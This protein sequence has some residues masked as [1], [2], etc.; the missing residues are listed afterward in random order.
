MV[1]LRGLYPVETISTAGRI[2]AE[3]EKIFNQ[4]LYFKKIVKYVEEPI[5][6][7]FR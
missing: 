6:C 2:C 1:T 4:D 3:A 7:Y 5:F